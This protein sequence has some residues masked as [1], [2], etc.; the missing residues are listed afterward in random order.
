MICIFLS[1]VATKAHIWPDE[2][3]PNKDDNKQQ[4]QGTPHDLP[5]FGNANHTKNLL[6]SKAAL[7]RVRGAV[8]NRSDTIQQ[9]ILKRQLFFRQYYPE[10]EWGYVILFCAFLCAIICQGIQLSIGILSL[11]AEFRF[12]RSFLPHSHLDYTGESISFQILHSPCQI[13]YLIFNIISDT[14]TSQ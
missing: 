2:E 12:F 6:T 14:D 8:R 5:I 4:H 10:G 13:R 3:D 1:E 9:Q 11:L 7:I